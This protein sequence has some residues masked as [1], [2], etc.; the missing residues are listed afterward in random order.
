MW[1]SIQRM[2]K[3]LISDE[4]DYSNIRTATKDTRVE[5]NVAI[6]IS[7][8]SYKWGK[9]KEKKEENSKQ[10]RSRE[11]EEKKEKKRLKKELKN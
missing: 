1:T 8:G 10:I 7:A 4:M 11:K 2:E 5:G 6:K 9:D 3:Y